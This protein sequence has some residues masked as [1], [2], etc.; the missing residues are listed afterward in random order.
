MSKFKR[1]KIIATLGPSSNN[2]I[3]IRKLILE[4]MNVARINMS[5]FKNIID[6]EN[7]IKIIRAE[8]KEC[9]EHIG[10][11]VDL[12]GPKIRLNL[13]NIENR[14][15]ILKK[16]K[17]YTLGYS[18]KNDL[19]INYDIKFSKSIKGK[20]FIKI[21]DGKTILEVVKND[22]DKLSVKSYDNII[23]KDRKGINF[24]NI[25]I[26]IDSITSSDKEHILLAIK[27]NVDWLALSF[28][29]SN[30]DI[31]PIMDIFKNKKHYIPIIAKI[32][33]PEAISNLDSIINTFDGILIARGDLGVEVS[34][35]ELP[36]LQKKIIEKCRKSKKPVIVATQ[37]LESMIDN[38]SPTRAEVNDVANAV[39]ESA[40]TVM[41]SAETAIGKY[42][43]ESVKIMKEILLNAEHEVF[44]KKLS[45]NISVEVDQD[46]RSAI[47]E[48]VNLISKHLNVDAI[49][50]MT[51]SG[52]TGIIVSHYRPTNQIFALTPNKSICNKL[53]LIWGVIPILTKEFQ[54][55]DEMIIESERL[56]LNHK[57]LKYK[58]TFVLTAGIPVGIAGTT[59]MLK[60]HRIIKKN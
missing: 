21:D 56:L 23:L 6:F 34:L 35:A 28:V 59:N 7:L 19:Q 32:E 38:A 10:I 17:V 53:S 57:F 37:M 18:P 1:T 46:A 55:T 29:R 3:I 14:K 13:A 26:D 22:I 45:E 58:D 43:V 36:G 24:P 54:S 33:K 41:L 5:H 49:V 44:K 9:N 30:E 40:D 39:Y 16:N 20:S 12:A 15:C 60:I 4:G 11:L 50:V 31:N 42:P 8:A 47:G 2:P 25:D 27:N 52:N 51:E 48:A